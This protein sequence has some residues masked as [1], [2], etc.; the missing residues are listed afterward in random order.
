[1]VFSMSRRASNNSTSV[2]ISTNY[3]SLSSSLVLFHRVPQRHGVEEPVD[4]LPRDNENLGG[5]TFPGVRSIPLGETNSL[6]QQYGHAH[7][8]IAPDY[9][10]CQGGEEPN[11]KRQKE[12]DYCKA[13]REIRKTRTGKCD[14]NAEDKRD[15]KLDKRFEDRMKLT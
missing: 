7:A 1:M 2:Y 9:I 15:E 6:H 10:V 3:G 5:T 4:D 14:R 12:K 11:P 13:I 8:S